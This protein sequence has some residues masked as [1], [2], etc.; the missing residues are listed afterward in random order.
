M[1]LKPDKPFKNYHD[2][3]QRLRDHHIVVLPEW[4][5]ITEVELQQYGYYNLANAYQDILPHNQHEQLTPPVPVAVI[6][7]IK[8]IDEILSGTLLTALIHFENTFENILSYQV[9]KQFGVFALDHTAITGYL[10]WK[11]YPKVNF[12]PKPTLKKLEEFVTGTDPNT[13]KN[14]RF[15]VS[16]SL[17][18]YRKKHNHIPPWILVNDISLGLAKRWYSICPS[19][20]KDAVANELFSSNSKL[21]LQERK[22]LLRTSLNIIESYRNSLAH[23]TS[24]WKTPA[25]HSNKASMRLSNSIVTAID[26]ASTISKT[27]LRNDIGVNDLYSLLLIIATQTTEYGN[28]KNIV[29]NL[30]NIITTTF[31]DEPTRKYVFNDILG[32]PK[33]FPERL[34]RLYEYYKNKK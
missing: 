21:T 9:A 22:Q 29:N 14:S 19:S 7:M 24:I 1:T 10:N 3:I 17:L 26:D 4:E 34:D 25:F 27:D 30:K 31:S 15:K 32:F 18:T 13:G 6:I 2:Q 20:I 5:T 11:H 23:G 28:M 33:D 12:S 8:G 16:S